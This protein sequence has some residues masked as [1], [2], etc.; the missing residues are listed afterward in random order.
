M[1]LFPPLRLELLNGWIPLL[2]FYVIFGALLRS[3]PKDVVQRLYDRSGWT[4]QQKTLGAIGLPFA[5]AAFGLLIFTPLK[6]ER[7][8][9][10]IG[11]IV[12][13]IGLGGMVTALFN[14][15]NTPM[16]QPVIHGLY[17]ISRNPQWVM[18][19]ILMVGMAISVGSWTIMLLFFMRAVF[20]HFRILG[21]EKACLESYGE[22]FQTYLQTVPRYFL[23][24]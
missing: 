21:E 12:Y 4:K 16:D 9:F 13:G 20:N 17:R 7:T 10:I 23:I 22:V 24:F 1:E 14:F 11:S 2:I 3:F 19:F 6:I 18:F 8:V 15:R 5:F